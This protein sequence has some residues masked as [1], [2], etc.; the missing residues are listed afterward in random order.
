MNLFKIIHYVFKNKITHFGEIYRLISFDYFIKFIKL[1]VKNASILD[2]GFN[3]G[4]FNWYFIEVLGCSNYTGIEIDNRY[5]DIYPNTYYHNFEKNILHKDFD[6]IFCSHVLE[7]V[8]NDYQFLKNMVQSLK[9]GSGK[10]LLR[11]PTPTDKK[12]YFRA[13]NS[14]SHQDNE[15]VRD[16]YTP[17]EL[18]ILSSKVGLKV[19]K[20]F[21][22]MGSLSLAMHT[23]FEIFRDYQIR[24]QRIFQIPYIFFSMMDMYLINK[25]SSSDLLVLAVIESKKRQN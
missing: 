9:N 23:L 5:L 17:S 1:D 16:G 14:K 22:N 6:L 10:L 13:F 21:F 12:I 20:Y 3:K 25:T 4:L 11:V 19:E 18:K 2:V 15:H 7:H 24:F 8:K